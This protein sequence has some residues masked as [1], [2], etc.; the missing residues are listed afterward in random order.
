MTKTCSTFCRCSSGYPFVLFAFLFLHTECHPRFDREQSCSGCA[1]RLACVD[2]GLQFIEKDGARG[3][4]CISPYPQ[5]CL[6][7]LI[8]QKLITKRPRILTFSVI[9][10]LCR[11]NRIERATINQTLT[12]CLQLI[13]L[14]N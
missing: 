9:R 2:L 11:K 8:A 12:I 4:P 5:C 14:L 6:D 13:L 3:L 10:G 7:F 1:V